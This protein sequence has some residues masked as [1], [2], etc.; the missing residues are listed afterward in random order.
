MPAHGWW[1][2]GTRM[3]NPKMP[4]AGQQ[5]EPDEPVDVEEVDSSEDGADE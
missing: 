2:D 3:P 4:E 1:P 5:D